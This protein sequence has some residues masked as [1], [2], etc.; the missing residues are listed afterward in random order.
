MLVEDLFKRE[1]VG[2][3]NLASSFYTLNLFK[4]KKPLFFTLWFGLG[5]LGRLAPRTYLPLVIMV[6]ND[7]LGMVG[8]EPQG[9][10]HHPLHID[11]S[12]LV[13]VV[14][15]QGHGRPPHFGLL[16]VWE[17]L[18][19]MAHPSTIYVIL[20]SAD[21]S[22]GGGVGGSPPFF[23]YIFYYIKQRVHFWKFIFDRRGHFN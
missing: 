22:W 2:R 7:S 15:W 14:G 17:G 12:R 19:V 13:W 23:I 8:S 16:V 3:S 11:P 20:L 5:R 6:R 10:A 9:S 4:F 1:E 21:K 18:G